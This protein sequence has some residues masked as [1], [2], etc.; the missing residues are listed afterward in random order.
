MG[1]AVGVFVGSLPIIPFQTAAAV[2]LALCFKCSKLTAA[3]GTWVSNPL[4]WYFLYYYSYK[5]GATVMGLPEHKALFSMILT[6]VQQ[7][8]SFIQVAETI[9][10]MGGLVAFAFVLGGSFIGL[11]LSPPAYFICLFIFK[12]FQKKSR[13]RKGRMLLEG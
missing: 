6:S 4:D 2:A 7:G 13:A 3:L 11:A 8:H 5:I 12:R 10:G 1:I 9:L